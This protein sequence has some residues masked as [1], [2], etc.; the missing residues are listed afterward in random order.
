MFTS[1]RERRLWIWTGIVVFAIYA[2]LGLAGSLAESLPTRIAIDQTFVYAFFILVGALIGIAI[3]KRPRPVELFVG[4]GVLAVYT[5]A[6]V[7]LGMAERTHLFEYSLVAVLIYQ[8]LSERRRNGASVP[9]PWVLTVFG[10]ALIGWMDEGIQ[11]LIPNRHYDWVDV[12]FN[13]LAAVVAGTA[14]VAVDWARRVAL[15][16][17]NPSD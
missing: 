15:A 11:A 14:S 12:G 6:F 4:V 8:A 1:K 3:F 7:R 16:R 9:S 5:M 10:T 17:L 2:T 13:A